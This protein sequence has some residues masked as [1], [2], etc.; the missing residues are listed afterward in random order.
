MVTRSGLFLGRTVDPV[1]GTT[2]PDPLFLNPTDL[3]THGVIVGMTGSGKTALGI[4]MIEEL[5]LSGVPVLAIDPK[6]DLGNLLL[7]FASLSSEEFAPW[8]AQAPGV[9]PDGEAKKWKDGLSGWG[10]GPADLAS[11]AASRDASIYTPGSTSGT[12]LDL[13]GSCAKPD[14]IESEES[15]EVVT[16]F[17]SGLLGLLGIEADPVRSREHI[18]LSKCIQAIWERGENATLESILATV[19]E[20]PF[21]T[22]GALPLESF[23]PSRQRQELVLTLNNLLASSSTEALRKGVP[24]RMDDFLGMTPGKKPRLSIVSI[25]HL[26]DAERIFVVGTLLAQVLAWVRRQPGSSTLKA[27]IY[28]DEIFGFFPP[29]AEPPTKRPL[30]TLLKQARAFGVGVVLA[31]QNPVDLDYKGLANC[32]AWW[33]GTLQTERDRNRLEE[34]LTSASGSDEPAKLLSK[35]RKRVFLL[36]DVHRSAP[37]LVET[38]W[39]MSYLRGPMTREEIARL[40]KQ[41]PP[42]LLVSR[43]GAP[44]LAGAPPPPATEKASAGSIA[45]VIPNPWSAKWCD[46]RNGDIAQ[47]FLYLRYAVRY[48]QGRAQ[49]EE[50]SATRLYPLAASSAAEVMEQDFRDVDPGKL[51]ES[52]PPRKIRYESL[53]S[54]LGSQGVK[55]LEKAVKERLPD[56]LAATLYLDPMT[57]KLSNP[58]ED[59]EIFA[60]RIAGT[61]SLPPALVDRLEKKKRELAKAIEDEKARSMETMASMAGAALDFASGLFGKRKTLKVGKVGGVLGKRRMEGAAEQKIEIL[62]QEVADLE[63][64]AGAPDPARFQRVEIVPSK[65]QIDILGIGVAWVS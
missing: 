22:V 4:V 42:P 37:A 7:N 13:L 53:P 24:V 59:V 31:T 14:D 44:G 18:L 38:R 16:A 52:A 36:H 15:R 3:T 40:K 47:P 49:S 46:L 48:K 35:T 58:G 26:S 65:A 19:A 45:P 55:Q 5:L 56:K 29:S 9:T 8:V 54:W 30:L 23:F 43:P 20:P 33:V 11:L 32:G 10:L 51:D 62:Q 21:A 63:A 50:L 39:A 34:G 41:M 2:K 57:G 60:A 17:V 12:P 25:G 6:G 1:T 64:K 28:I 27:V 61:A